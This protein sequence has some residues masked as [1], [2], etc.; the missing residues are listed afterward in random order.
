MIYRFFK[1]RHAHHKARLRG[2]KLP[3]GA[4]YVRPA[5]FYLNLKNTK[6]Q[7]WL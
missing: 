7:D 5:F 1:I 3:H 2:A 6:L 4:K